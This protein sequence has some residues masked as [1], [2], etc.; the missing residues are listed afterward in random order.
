MLYGF[1][2]YR[3]KNIFW[4]HNIY[5]KNKRVEKI[6]FFGILEILGVQLLLCLLKGGDYGKY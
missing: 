5:R 2:V 4:C 6:I 3:I 1:A